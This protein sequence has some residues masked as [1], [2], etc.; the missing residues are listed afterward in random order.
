MK[1]KSTDAA[2][3]RDGEKNERYEKPVTVN[4]EHNAQVTD[5]N[6]E[7]IAEDESEL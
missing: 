7:N 2:H 4:P 6:V 1:D 5:S 3:R